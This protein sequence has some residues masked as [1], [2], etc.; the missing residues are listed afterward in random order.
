MSKLPRIVFDYENQ[1]YI[2]I[3]DAVNADAESRGQD[4]YGVVQPC[5]HRAPSSGCYSCQ[6]VGETVKV[7]NAFSAQERFES[8]TAFEG[9]GR[10]VPGADLGAWMYMGE[11]MNGLLSFKHRDTRLYMYLSPS[12]TD[13][14]RAY[15][16]SETVRR[17]GYAAGAPNDGGEA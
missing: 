17:K 10:A 5:G 6:H 11:T 9:L 4:F 13:K 12:W 3:G 2:S 8:R 15:I 1:A 14:D 7:K 16:P